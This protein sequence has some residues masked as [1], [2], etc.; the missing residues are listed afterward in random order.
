MI[1]LYSKVDK[2]LQKTKKGKLTV[3][4][5]MYI[6]TSEKN[7]LEEIEKGKNLEKQE[8]ERKQMAEE[9][10]RGLH[11][12]L[13][14]DATNINKSK[15]LTKS[16]NPVKSNESKRTVR[17]NSEDETD[18]EDEA[19]VSLRESSCCC[20]LFML[21]SRRKDFYIM[22]YYLGQV[23]KKYSPDEYQ[24]PFL[25]ILK[26]VFSKTKDKSTVYSSDVVCILLSSQPA[27]TSRTVYILSFKKDL[28]VY[29][30]G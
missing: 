8:I 28:S 5:R 15:R 22:L 21:S 4:S 2:T 13:D 24:V 16:S 14:T 30:V 7:R 29:D 3:K 23:I 20:A 17:S 27:I 25:N 1:R 6:D 19:N 18:F 10:K 26:F 9:F 11:L 12:L